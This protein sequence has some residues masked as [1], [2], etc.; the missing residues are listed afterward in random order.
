MDS[1]WLIKY[2]KESDNQY[3]N[4][5][6]AVIMIPT[7]YKIMENKVFGIVIVIKRESSYWFPYP[8]KSNITYMV[9]QSRKY[10]IDDDNNYKYQSVLY[11]EHTFEDCLARLDLHC[12]Q[13]LCDRRSINRKAFN[14]LSID[15]N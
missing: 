15:F 11:E 1:I 7:I 9:K 10:D 12:G 2:N 13:L 5:D 6:N 4:N 3:T 14:D 8:R